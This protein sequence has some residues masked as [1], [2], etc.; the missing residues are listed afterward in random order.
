[1]P[2]INL[3]LCQTQGAHLGLDISHA[4][5]EAVLGLRRD[6]KAFSQGIGTVCGRPP[7]KIPLC[8]SKNESATLAVQIV[9][10]C[11]H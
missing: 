1:M 9:N 6:V 11:Q 2:R 4:F 5:V 7:A 10:T 3:R 8:R